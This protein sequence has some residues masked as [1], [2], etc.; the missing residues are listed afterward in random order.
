[1]VKNAEVIGFDRRVGGPVA[2][3]GQGGFY[4]LPKAII[5]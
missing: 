2:E 3:F 4:T 5:S 1:V